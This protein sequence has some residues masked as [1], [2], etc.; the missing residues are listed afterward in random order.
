M[1]FPTKAAFFTAVIITA[2]LAVPAVGQP[3]R[4]IEVGQKIEPRQLKTI[5]R[6]KMMLPVEE[7][8]TVVLFWSTEPSFGACSSIVEEICGPVQGAQHVGADD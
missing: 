7:G 4:G 5:D 2:T 1:N 6:E 3:E 8:L